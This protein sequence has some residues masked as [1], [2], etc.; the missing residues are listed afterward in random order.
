LEGPDR[1]PR[2]E[3]RRRS[4]HFALGRD[5]RDD[6][7]FRR[8]DPAPLLAESLDSGTKLR[9][10]GLIVVRQHRDDRRRVPA[11]RLV[12]LVLRA[13]EVGEEPVVLALGNRIVFVAMAL[14]TF[15]REAEPDRRGRLDAIDDVFDAVLL[16]DDAALVG[17]AVV[18]VEARRDALGSGRVLEEIPGH[19]LD[20]EAVEGQILVVG[21]NHPIAPRP[22]V[23][24]SIGVEDARIAV[25]RGIHPRERHPLSETG[26]SE[27]PV[28]EAL[29]GVGPLIGG[30]PFD[31]VET[32]G[33]AG[34][35]EARS[36]HESRPVGFGSRGQALGPQPFLD[37]SVDRVACL[38]L[39]GKFRHEGTPRRHEGPVIRP[40]SAFVDPAPDQL[41]L[42]HR[43]RLLRRGR[44]HAL[45]RVG[46]GDAAPEFARAAVARDEHRAGIPRPSVHRPEESLARVEAKRCLALFRIRPVAMNARAEE[47]RLDLAAKI[48]R[49]RTRVGQSLSLPST[50]RRLAR[51]RVLGVEDRERPETDDREQ[52]DSADSVIGDP[53]GDRSAARDPAAP[54]L[55]ARFALEEMKQDLERSRHEDRYPER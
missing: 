4:Q 3:L 15:H 13:I 45:V 14:G 28:D 23:P 53:S 37:E 31:L 42:G 9:D 32:R 8:H 26:G 34:Q 54:A 29:V 18:A 46:R 39:V 1:T 21:P 38:R 24:R 17:S 47:E 19:L 44:R 55:L 10:A 48:H 33:Q 16:V 41:D 11:P 51:R 2:P 35:S 50:A 20:G 36:A 27:K 43:E 7:G 12:A 6:F 49:R 52:D 5:P 30:E 40:R 25:A 22:H